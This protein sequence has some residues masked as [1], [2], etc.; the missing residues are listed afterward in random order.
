MDAT[1]HLNDNLLTTDQL[2]F[3]SSCLHET[4]VTHVVVN[5][6]ITWVAEPSRDKAVWRAM[7]LLDQKENTQ[8]VSCFDCWINGRDVEDC[9]HD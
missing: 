6:S 3:L 2:S 8:D 1:D 5:G 4:N 9:G 7:K